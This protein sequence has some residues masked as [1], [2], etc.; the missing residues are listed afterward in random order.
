MGKNNWI[1]RND[2]SF[3]TER[4][5]KTPLIPLLKYRLV[6]VV[7][8]QSN[9]MDQINFVRTKWD[10]FVLRKDLINFD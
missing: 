9:S 4:E 6:V 8:L 1:W 5:Q 7:G 3:S 2:V 10:F